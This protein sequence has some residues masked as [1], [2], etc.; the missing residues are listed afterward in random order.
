MSFSFPVY[1]NEQI[2]ELKVSFLID[3]GSYNFEVLK[4]T[5]KTSSKGNPMM[6][7]QLKVWDNNGKEHIIYDYLLS[8][9][10]WAFKI[11]HFCESIGLSYDKGGFETWDCENKFGKCEI[12]IQ[13]GAK[14]EDG[15]FYPEKNSVKDYIKKDN[16]PSTSKNNLDMNDDLPF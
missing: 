6:E 9:P 3:P 15:S 2:E 13:K 8:S 16:L 11:K 14:K 10:T 1:T 5:N 7:M 4:A 12:I